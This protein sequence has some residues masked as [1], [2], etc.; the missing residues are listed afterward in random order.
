MPNQEPSAIES[1]LRHPKSK[2]TQ[3]CQNFQLENRLHPGRNSIGILFALREER[4]LLNE[5]IATLL[6]E[7]KRIL[8]VA[9]AVTALSCDH[10]LAPLPS[11]QP[12]FGGIVSFEKNTWPADSLVNL[13]IFASQVYPLDSA[14]VFGGLLS[15]P[16]TIFVYSLP[17]NVDSVS[18][19]FNL[20]PATYKYVGVV[21]HLTNDFTI[22]SLRVV[23]L[24]GTNDVPP[25]PIPVEVNDRT[26]PTGIDMRVNFRKPP[27][28]P[29]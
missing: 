12:G 21:Q 8:L 2:Y 15:S 27:P 3:D 29:F 23:G 20:P 22:H 4:L 16:A 18:Y 7:M 14:K 6:Q 5:A 13:W 9:I 28:Q 17:F 10:G 24:Y 26:F 11:V 1:V 19:T 25:V